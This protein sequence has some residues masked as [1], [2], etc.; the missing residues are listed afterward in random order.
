VLR[1]KFL[2]DLTFKDLHE[3]VNERDKNPWRNWDKY[4]VINKQKLELVDF[5]SDKELKEA[6]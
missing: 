4:R 1:L 5:Q 2:R 6:V 3:F